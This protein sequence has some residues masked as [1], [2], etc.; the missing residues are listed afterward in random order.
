MIKKE[1]EDEEMITNYNLCDTIYA[2][3]KVPTVA[4][5]RAP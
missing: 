1:E 2:A 5:L 4:I 3:A